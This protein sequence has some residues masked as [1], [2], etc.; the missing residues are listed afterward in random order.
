MR[1]TTIVAGTALISAV[2]AIWGT[3]IIIA[4]TPKN[5]A[6]VAAST[7]ISVLEMMKNSKNLPEEAF[8]AH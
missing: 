7:S 6:P 5:S 8:D 3:T 1:Q 2:I 4:H